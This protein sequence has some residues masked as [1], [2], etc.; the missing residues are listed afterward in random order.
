LISEFSGNFF[1]YNTKNR[2][3]FPLKTKTKTMKEETKQWLS[4]RFDI[5]TEDIVWY[6]SGICYDR[7]KVKTEES[8][9][10]IQESVEGQ[11]V[12]GGWLHGMALGNYTKEED[13]YDVMC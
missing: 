2:N 3:Y 9:K 5:P 6:N 12:N 10:K 8:V 7:I 11:Y 13:G 4:K 1:H